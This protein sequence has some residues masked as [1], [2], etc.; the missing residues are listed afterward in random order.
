LNRVEQEVITRVNEITTNLETSCMQKLSIDARVALEKFVELSKNYETGELE[1][2]KLRKENG[3]LKSNIHS[4][5]IHLEV[6][7][8][9]LYEMLKQLNRKI[10]NKKDVSVQSDQ[11]KTNSKSK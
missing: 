4:L 11:I 9:L 6:A 1:N 5:R 10:H 2:R 3:F 8:S 7:E